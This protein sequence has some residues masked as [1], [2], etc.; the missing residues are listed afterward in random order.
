MSRLAFTVFSDLHHH[1]VWYKTEAP[2]RLAAIQQRALDSGSAFLLHLG[3]FSH[4]PSR[5]P[6]LIRQYREFT[7]AGSLVV[8]PVFHH[9]LYHYDHYQLGFHRLVPD[10]RDPRYAAALH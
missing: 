8:D 5:C 3:D 2:E 1:P 10:R 7:L 9:G 4:Q 6:E